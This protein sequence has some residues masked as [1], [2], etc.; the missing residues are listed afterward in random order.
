M[1]LTADGALW[2]C[3]DRWPDASVPGGL[4][5]HDA[6]GWKT[7]T[8]TDAAGLDHTMEFFCD[9][10]SREFVLTQR[11]LLEKRGEQWF[12]PLLEA[13]LEG[14]GETFWSMAEVPGVGLMA[15]AFTGVFF[16]DDRQGR[17]AHY[18]HSFP[19]IQTVASTRSGE[20]LGVGLGK[21]DGCVFK[22]WTREGFVT[23][24]ELFPL[25]EVNTV[26]FVEASDGALWVGGYD[27]LEQLRQAQKMESVGRLAGGVAHDFN[28]ML[29]AILGN[30]ELA[31]A[32]TAPGTELHDDLRE[33]QRSADLTRQL[34]AFARKQTV[35]P[36]VLDLNDTI[37]GML[38]MLQRLIGEEVQ[39]LWAPGRDLWPV[40]VDPGQINQLLANLTVNARDAISGVGR[41]TIETSNV[42]LQASDARTRADVSP[43]DYVQLAVQDNG[44][45]I[46]REVMQHL[47]EPFFTTKEV[48]K[49]TGLGLATVFGIVQQNGGA[50]T[51]ESEPGQGSVFRVLL[52]RAEA[53]VVVPTDPPSPRAFAGT[54]TVLLV[55]DEVKVLRLGC[56][57]LTR[58][59]YVLLTASTPQAALE[60]A[61]RHSGRIDLLVTDGVRLLNGGV[62]FV[63]G[64]E[65]G[66]RRHGRPDLRTSGIRFPFAD[67]A[68]LLVDVM[69][70][71]VGLS[72]ESVGRH[73]GLPVEL[74]SRRIRQV[75]MSGGCRNPER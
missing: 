38:K 10:R 40:K 16:W 9:S 55:E 23:E 64:G 14:S 3:S 11:G 22:R 41:V 30:V 56:R 45:G 63:W 4:T 43:G 33:I 1:A 19:Q 66:R 46:E 2:F 52:P 71:L 69:V 58:L 42:S 26:F 73:D 21:G 57:I 72:H 68:E 28:N 65:S 6:R 48:G 37:S 8:R 74:P 59:G 35:H 12:S 44:R 61:T 62:E 13:G 27:Y 7:Y 18:A 75:H 32:Q 29:Q 17:W 24:S 39:L 67:D 20:F 53:V 25:P 54:E 15:N 5:R 51:V 50:I 60:L 47:L 49:G 36:K 70:A 34:L 31:L